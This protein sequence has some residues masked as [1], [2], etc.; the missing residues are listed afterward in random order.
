V[1]AKQGH[2]FY[3]CAIIL[4]TTTSQYHC[5]LVLFTEYLTHIHCKCVHVLL[6]YSIV[7]YSI[8]ML[9]LLVFLSNLW[10]KNFLRDE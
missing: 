4:L 9:M 7:Y 5:Q 8:A 3:F 1:T 6:Y 2:S 10:H